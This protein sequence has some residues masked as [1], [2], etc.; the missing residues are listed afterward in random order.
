MEEKGIKIMNYLKQKKWMI[1]IIFV[2]VALISF[3]SISTLTSSP[4]FHQSSIQALD[5]KKVTVMELVAA[6]AATSTAISLIPGDAAMPI[7]NQISEISNY[8]LIVI[9]VIIIEKYMLTISGFIAFK[10]LIPIACIFGIL[11][12]FLKKGFFKIL[13]IKLSI[14]AVAFFLLVPTSVQITQIIETAYQTSIQETIDAAQESTIEKDDKDNG[15]LSGI[16]SS[17]EGATTKAIEQAKTMLSNFVDAIA[18]LMV[19]SCFIPILVVLC[20]TWLVK[21]IFNIQINVPTQLTTISKK[22]DIVEDTQQQIN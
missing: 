5:D 4:D 17:V 3:F 22:K 6:T 2:I 8:L 14:F 13:A 7:A 10:F 18:V 15:F 16:I 21:M 20:F 12:L 11:Y 1:S 9:C 19:T